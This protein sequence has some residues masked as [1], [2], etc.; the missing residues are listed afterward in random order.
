M[1]KK[2]KNVVQN[3]T[4]REVKEKDFKQVIDILHKYMSEFL[5]D[6]RYKDIIFN[7]FISQT[8]VY[9]VVAEFEKKIIGYGC[10]IFEIK[11]RGSK[12]GHIEDIVTDK[13]FRKLGVGSL[14][15]NK[16]YNRAQ[17]EKCYKICL[18]SFKDAV[19]F[20]KKNGFKDSGSIAMSMSL[21]K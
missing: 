20:Y 11:I 13:N 9:G 12:I 2:N 7:N 8:N 16:L 19:P 17:K 3:L 1:I 14:I 18:A 10:I 6:F 21:N 5:P 15:L 4:L